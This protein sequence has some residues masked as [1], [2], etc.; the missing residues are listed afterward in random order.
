MG[1]RPT[2]LPAKQNTTS[3]DKN[4]SQNDMN[5]KNSH[6]TAEGCEKFTRVP[7]G[8]CDVCDDMNAAHD[9][10]HKWVPISNAEKRLKEAIDTIEARYI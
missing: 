9:E 4:V 2:K 7:T 6:I 10:Y 3:S 1:K 8:K 5:N